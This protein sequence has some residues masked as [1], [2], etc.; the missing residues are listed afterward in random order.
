VQVG[1][2]LPG[3]SSNMDCGQAHPQKNQIG[4]GGAIDG[5]LVEYVVLHQDGVVL[6]PDHLSYE[7][8]ATLPVRQ[9]QLGIG[10]SRRADSRRNCAAVRNR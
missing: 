1:D 2:A 9:S 5:M 8:G 4:F 3:S 10:A 6:L 7:E